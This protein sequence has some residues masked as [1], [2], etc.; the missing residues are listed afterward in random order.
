MITLDQVNVAL[1]ILEQAMPNPDHKAAAH[2]VI[3][4][5]LNQREDLSSNR[6]SKDIKSKICNEHIRKGL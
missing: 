6:P 4:D 1:K 3:L 5:Y 2:K